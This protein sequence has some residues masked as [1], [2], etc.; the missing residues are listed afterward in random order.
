MAGN[1]ARLRD[2]RVVPDASEAVRGESTQLSPEQQAAAEQEQKDAD[3]DN[4]QTQDKIMRPDTHEVEL[5][6]T[7]KPLTLHQLSARHQVKF[8]GFALSVIVSATG[9]TKGID[10]IGGMR[11]ASALAEND[12]H[13]GKVCLYA[14]LSMDKPGKITPDQAGKIAL[15]FVQKS[16]LDD[17]DVLF[18]AL[19]G[20]NNFDE[21]LKNYIKK[22]L[23]V[24]AEDKDKPPTPIL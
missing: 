19:C 24:P 15:E 16:G 23:P 6:W 8:H 5:S 2:F 17:L 11:I 9:P 18:G 21:V 12:E 3:L 13:T 22:H 14:A 1:A 7:T 4:Q 20:L 10:M